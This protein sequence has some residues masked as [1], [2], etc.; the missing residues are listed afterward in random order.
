MH[1]QHAT[2]GGRGDAGPE[3]GG[4]GD[5]GRGFGPPRGGWGGGPG[6]RGGGRRRRGDIRTA[7]L[8]VLAEGPG[9]GYDLMS[10]LE[11]KS[12]G[13]WRPSAGSVYPTLQQLED[14]GLATSAETEGKRVYTITADG[15]AEAARRIEEAGEPWATPGGGGVHPGLLFRSLGALAMAA[16]QTVAA[17]NRGAAGG[18][19]P[20]R[21][22]RPQG[23]L[24]GAR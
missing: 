16:K 23:P 9:H 15:A 22:Q 6:H 14:E 8:A 19:D 5:F 7:V 17:G 11:N 12:D 20:H 1:M 24:P 2:R 3:F 18:G 10:R 4:R 21:R 13:A